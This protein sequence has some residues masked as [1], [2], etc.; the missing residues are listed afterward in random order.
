MAKFDAQKALACFKKA[1]DTVGAAG[2]KD[3]MIQINS[4]DRSL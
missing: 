1:G 2:L 3:L 4:Q